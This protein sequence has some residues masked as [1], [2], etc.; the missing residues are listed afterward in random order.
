[1]WMGCGLSKLSVKIS[2]SEYQLNF[3]LES[4]LQDIVHDIWKEGTTAH[5]K[6]S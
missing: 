5:M 6:V 4:T 1:M 2:A 3:I